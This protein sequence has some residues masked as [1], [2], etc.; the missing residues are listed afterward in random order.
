MDGKL[1]GV[2]AVAIAVGLI[3]GAFPA[4][5]STPGVARTAQ[6]TVSVNRTN[7]GDR[8]R[9]SAPPLSRWQ[10]ELRRTHRSDVTQRSAVSQ[11][12]RARISL[13]AAF[14]EFVRL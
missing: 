6:L 8:C 3:A 13:G 14:P 12:L 11:I 4:V 7:K 9:L 5:V 1:K 10:W 2:M